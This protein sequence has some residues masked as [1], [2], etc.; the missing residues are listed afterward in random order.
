MGSFQNLRKKDFK[1]PLIGYLN[2]NSLRNGIIDLMKIVRYLEL[3]YLVIK[4]TKVNR[5]FPSQ[6]FSIDNFEVSPRKDKTVM[7]V[8]HRICQKRFYLLRD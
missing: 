5:N 6:Q 8:F 4:E 3:G 7:G 2:I 1:N